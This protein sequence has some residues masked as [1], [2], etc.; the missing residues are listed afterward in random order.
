MSTRNIDDGP[1]ALRLSGSGNWSYPDTPALKNS[2]LVLS[3]ALK[4]TWAKTITYWVELYGTFGPASN[5]KIVRW[6][7]HNQWYFTERSSAP[8]ISPN[9]VKGSKLVPG[10]T[11][12]LYVVLET[13]EIIV[14]DMV[15][16]RNYEVANVLVPEIEP[17]AFKDGAKEG[18]IA[19]FDNI[20]SSNKPEPADEL[21]FETTHH[22][23]EENFWDTVRQRERKAKW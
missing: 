13:A 18:V 14:K 16:L 4:K 15:K 5:T 7:V 2:V 22:K 8:G 6:Y 11:T 19:L 10:E 23:K 17:A 1:R 3:V 9:V 21:V 20:V 12:S